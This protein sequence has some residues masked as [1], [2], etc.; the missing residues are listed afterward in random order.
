MLLK[1]Y[2]VQCTMKESPVGRRIL[3]A[4]AKHGDLSERVDDMFARQT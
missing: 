3:N 1:M 4:I 2:N